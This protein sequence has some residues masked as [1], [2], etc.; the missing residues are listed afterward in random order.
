MAA[1]YRDDVSGRRY[2]Y[3][4]GRVV[5]LDPETVAKAPS[6]GMNG[7]APRKEPQ[8]GWPSLDVAAFHGLAGKVVRAIEPHSEADPA[9][10]LLTFLAFFGSAVGRGPHAMADG[11][12]HP[13]RLNV[14]LVGD[15][16]RSR[17]GTS[18]ARIRSVFELADPVWAAERIMSG[19]GSGEVLVDT[20][21]DREDN[22]DKRLL[23]LEGE[24][25]RILAV[26]AR[27]GSTLSAI[28]RDAWDKDRLAARSRQHNVVATGAHVSFVAHITVEELRRRL[29]ETEIANGLA[30][31]FLF[32]CVRRGHL[33]PEGG[34]LTAAELE[35]LGREVRTALQEARKITVLG[36]SETATK[37]WAQMYDELAKGPGGLAGAITARA[38][39][40]TLRLS[41]AYALID[42]SAVI[43]EQH[44]EAAYA[45]WN[46]CEA[47]ALHIF[48][49][50]LGDDIA[51]RLLKAISDAGD[52][53]LD[54]TAQS[55]VFGRNVSAKRLATARALLEKLGLIRTVPEETDGRPRTVSYAN[56]KHTKK[57]NEGGRR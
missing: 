12:R 25:V 27:E 9:G 11:S 49:D 14:A 26:A 56:T 3:D 57:T 1:V 51:D 44:L 6:S 50:Q 37:R 16:S 18:A 29:S 33:L 28:I 48:G 38:E 20:V 15:T 34:C 13:A 7:A 5:Y 36:R 54:F 53:G 4:D 24:F 39:S 32:G 30:N 55:A 2:R 10:L 43:N 45:V 42:G 22:T 40:Q 17:K 47:S 19:F 31:R 52:N 46:Y 21:G 35:G 23:V 41:V 8:D